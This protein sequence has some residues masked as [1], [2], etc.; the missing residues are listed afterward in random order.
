MNVIDFFDRGANLYPQRTCLTDGELALSY[1]ETQAYTHRIALALQAQQI[2]EGNK[3]AVYSP[4]HVLGYMATLGIYRAAAVMVP[5]NAKNALEEN[6][7]ILQNTDVEWL[8]YHSMFEVMISKVRERVPAIRGFICVDKPGENSR[9]EEAIP[10]LETWCQGFKGQVDPLPENPK[11]LT[12]LGA[13][14]GTTGQP[15]GACLTNRCL[16][17]MVASYLVGMPCDQPANHLIVAPVTHA[18]GAIVLP[19]LS[20]GG[21]QFMSSKTDPELIMQMI[22]RHNITHLFLPPTVIYLMLAHPKVRD[23]DYSSLK[24]FL[25]AAAP[26]SGDKLRQA[27]EI[28][29]P[30]MVQSYGQA[31]APMYCTFMSVQDHLDA[32]KLGNEQRLLSCGKATPFT[33][34][35]IMDDDGNLLDH[36][37]HGEIVVRGSLVMDGYYKNPEATEE[38][39]AFGWHHTGD[40]GYIDDD[41]FVFIVDRKKD[42]IITGGF[43]VFPSE[44]EQVIWSHPAVQDC[45][46][47]GV[48]DEK[49]GEAVKAVIEAV[50]GENVDEKEIIAL[51]KEKLGSVKAPKSVEVWEKL[52]RSPVGKVLKKEIRKGFWQHQERM[53]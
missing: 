52:P 20:Q 4:N 22:E 17:T 48:P 47:I 41:G 1:S 43:N 27:I 45:A 38:S 12:L 46:V 31:E 18:A 2:G 13:T 3:V 44:I 24:Y 5:I 8:F 16:E 32:L 25:Y 21:T 30:V 14:G 26:M 34:L 11:R 50:S 36:N 7:Y 23:Y 53:L 9:N 6:I 28:F 29:G 42:M 39:R 51:C 37:A 49:W 15:K 19:L 10:E 33:R 40:I 35:G